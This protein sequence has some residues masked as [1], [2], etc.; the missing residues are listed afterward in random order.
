MFKLL[1]D[2]ILWTSF[3]NC[4]GNSSEDYTPEVYT[5]DLS[6]LSRVDSFLSIMSDL[7]YFFYLRDS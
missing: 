4:M 3:K 7:S 1:A 2:Y 6:S 5:R